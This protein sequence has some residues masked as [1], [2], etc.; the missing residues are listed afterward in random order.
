MIKLSGA[1]IVEGYTED[2][3]RRVRVSLWSDT[4]DEVTGV[5]TGENIEGLKADDVLTMGSTVL[6]IVDLS[7]GRLGSNG[8]WKF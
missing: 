8:I 1:P 3:R 5:T 7:L 4:E 6:T 2:N